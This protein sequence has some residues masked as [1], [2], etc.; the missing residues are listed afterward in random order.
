[1]Y[2]RYAAPFVFLVMGIPPDFHKWLVT[3]GVHKVSSRLELLFIENGVPIAHDYA[4]TLTNY[5]LRIDTDVL[6]K[7]VHEQVKKSVVKLLF[8]KPSEFSTLI[9]KFI[10]RYLSGPL[11]PYNLN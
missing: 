3:V 5:N 6:C 4:I 1:M 2:N 8:D 7:R 11:L 9:L 10:Q